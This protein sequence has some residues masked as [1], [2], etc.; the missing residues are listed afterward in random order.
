MSATMAI[1][2]QLA[3]ADGLIG[4]AL[5]AQLLHKTFWT[6]SVWESQEALQRFNHHDP[7]HARVERIR[8]GMLPAA[9][10]FWNTRGSALPIPWDEARRRLHARRPL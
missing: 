8:P 6:L 4:Y 3:H 1:R 5:D 10:V 2:N 7:H 9:F